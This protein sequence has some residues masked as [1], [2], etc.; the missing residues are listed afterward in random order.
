MDHLT[1]IR[2][3]KLS[4]IKDLCIKGQ[5][6]NVPNEYLAIVNEWK[7]SMSLG[8]DVDMKLTDKQR[9]FEVF[10]RIDELHRYHLSYLNGYYSS[11]EK[12]LAMHGCAIFYLDETLSAYNKAGDPELLKRL[13][14][15]GV[16]IGTNFSEK[17]VG[18]FVANIALKSPLKTCRRVG[19]EN[20]LNIFTKY[21]CYARYVSKVGRRFR[22]VNLIFVPEEVYCKPIHDSIN[23]ILEAEDIS[24]ASDFI[25]P[26]LASRIN[27]LEKIAQQ[28]NDIMMLV[29]AKMNV[30]FVNELYTKE[31][32]KAHSKEEPEALSGFMP[33]V[34]NLPQLKR[35]S[36]EDFSSTLLLHCSSGEDNAYTVYGQYVEGCGF[37]I[38]F[39]PCQPVEK[40]QKS[41][42]V[43]SFSSLIGRSDEFAEAI[44]SAKRAAK[45][46]GNVLILGE[47]GTGKELVAQAI[48][49]ASPRNTG[50]FIPLNCASIPKDLISSELM[51]Y[52]DG[53]FTGAKRG[54]QAGKFEL[55]NGGTIFL[56][57]I[58]EMPMDMQCSLLRILE[59]RVVCRIG[60]SKYYPVNVRIVAATNRDLWKCVQHGTFRLDLYFRLNVIRIE[61]PPLRKRTGDIDILVPYLLESAARKNRVPMVTISPEVM[62]LF[63]HYY[64]PGNVRELKNVVE[65][66]AVLTVSDTVTMENLPKDV[67]RQLSS[68]GPG[69]GFEPLVNPGGYTSLAYESISP[70]IPDS[71]DSKTLSP[72]QSIKEHE[73]RLIVELMKKYNGNKSKVAKEM[74]ISRSTLYK[75]LDEIS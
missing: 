39:V 36:K 27:F 17:N 45:G 7:S 46:L 29:D 71:I 18:V 10:R 14:A 62:E 16:R 26:N 49:E 41:K 15:D 69:A 47:S 34:A 24:A 56:D 73:T 43:Y 74:G 35:G 68:T 4:R 52:E 33:E 72:M 59:D 32:G 12:L 75:R 61:L 28:G 50:P 30:I 20:Y 22:S 48:H 42:A 66:C 21:I 3:N 9:D 40:T 11:K 1:S 57:E 25:Y 54:G 63:R 64:W 58:A 23:F 44:E 65:K 70:T 8:I 6:G 38:F 37:K 60:G 31:F 13:K 51:G 53:A 67:M 19:Q 55:A 2:D 5:I